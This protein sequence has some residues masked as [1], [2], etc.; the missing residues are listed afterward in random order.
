MRLWIVASSVATGWRFLPGALSVAL[1][2]GKEFFFDI[3]KVLFYFLSPVTFFLAPFFL[4]LLEADNAKR[5][6]EKRDALNKRGSAFQ[7][8]KYSEQRGPGSD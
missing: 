6:R 2:S 5:A 7:D 8:D 1:E 4:W 3:C